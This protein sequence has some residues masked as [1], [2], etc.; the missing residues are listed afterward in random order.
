[1]AILGRQSPCIPSSRYQARPALYI[2]AFWRVQV[3]LRKGFR[4]GQPTALHHPE[5]GMAREISLW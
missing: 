5:R 2:T 3:P 1:M 4:F